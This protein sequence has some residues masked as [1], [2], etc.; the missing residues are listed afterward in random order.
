[1]V[2]HRR[3]R[4]W[5]SRGASHSH[6]GSSVCSSGAEEWTSQLLCQ[7]R[8]RDKLEWIA[9]FFPLGDGSRPTHLQMSSDHGSAEAG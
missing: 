6:P 5:R 8:T 1:M 4:P 3:M 7:T 9:P 2:T